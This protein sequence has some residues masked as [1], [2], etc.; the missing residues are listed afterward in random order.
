MCRLFDD[1]S[2]NMAKSWP[3]NTERSLQAL[4]EEEKQIMESEGLPE[5]ISQ[6]SSD[7]N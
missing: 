3:A 6:I 5:L 1:A 2:Y 7:I 4:I